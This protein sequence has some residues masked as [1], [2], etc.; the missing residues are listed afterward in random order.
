MSESKRGTF[1]KQEVE[2]RL[3]R[4]R[5]TMATTGAMM[6][7]LDGRTSWGEEDCDDKCADTRTLLEGLS[8]AHVFGKEAEDGKSICAIISRAIGRFNGDKRT[9][10][11]EVRAS[12]QARDDHS[13]QPPV[14]YRDFFVT[15]GSASEEI[16]A[17]LEPNDTRRAAIESA[18]CEARQ[19]FHL[20]MLR[21]PGDHDPGLCLSI[22]DGWNPENPEGDPTVAGLVRTFGDELIVQV[23][24]EAPDY[25]REDIPWRWRSHLLRFSNLFGMTNPS[26]GRNTNYKACLK[27]EQTGD[28]LCEDEVIQASARGTNQCA[29]YSGSG[30]TC[31]TDQGS[32]CVI[33]EGEPTEASDLCGPPPS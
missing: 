28:D 23:M 2:M 21:L 7:A 22:I 11:L 20:P 4:R 3:S 32:K 27:R 15:D 24:S 26:D 30:W 16:L 1:S 12:L 33:S 6:M 18:L 19:Y 13:D 17:E 10:L 25:T 5:F 29:A 9:K 31:Q 8:V 14:C